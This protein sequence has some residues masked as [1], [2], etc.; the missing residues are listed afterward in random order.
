SR[1]RPTRSSMRPGTL[2]LL[3]SRGDNL[4]IVPSRTSWTSQGCEQKWN[5]MGELLLPEGPV[6]NPPWDMRSAERALT[7]VGQEK[8]KTSMDER[9][10][11]VRRAVMYHSTDRQDNLAT[12]I[13]AFCT[14]ECGAVKPLSFFSFPSLQEAVGIH[15][16]SSNPSVSHKWKRIRCE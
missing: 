4:T 1:T 16:A 3:R 7:T 5:D 11:A 9:Q 6:K 13:Q 15:A 2:S 8:P 12:K 14:L 10:T